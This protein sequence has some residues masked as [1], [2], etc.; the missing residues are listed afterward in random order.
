MSMFETSVFIL[1]W[2]QSG[3]QLD[4]FDHEQLSRGARLRFP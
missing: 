3:G 2:R 4:N 1:S